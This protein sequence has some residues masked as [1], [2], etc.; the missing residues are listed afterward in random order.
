MFKQIIYLIL[1]LFK[2]RD[3]NLNQ[4]NRFGM[5][6]TV[7]KN[8]EINQDFKIG[9]NYAWI[10]FQIAMFKMYKEDELLDYDSLYKKIRKNVEFLSDNIEL[11][12]LWNEEYIE[13]IRTEDHFKNPD[14]NDI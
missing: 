4:Y 2:D 13:Y 11:L 10:M 12:K 7:I 3:S 9:T 6:T 1:N 14:I 8:Q 5:N